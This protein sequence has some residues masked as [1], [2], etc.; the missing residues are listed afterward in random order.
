MTDVTFRSD[1]TVQYIRGIAD[2]QGVIDAAKVSTLGA[3]AQS[4]SDAYADLTPDEF[5]KKLARDTGFINFLTANR[6]GSPFEH[7]CMTFLVSAPIFVFREFMRHRIGISYNE[8]SGRYSILGAEF[9]I[10]G[11]ERAL[12]QI[13]K[14]GAYHYVA[15][16]ESQYE[17]TREVHENTA[18]VAYAGYERL[19]DEGVAKEVARM[20]LPLN[21]FSTMYVTLNARSMMSFL[22]LRTKREDSTFPSYPQREIE[23]VAEQMEAVF[24]ELMP[25]TH[26]TFDKNG[27]VSP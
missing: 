26:A 21:I 8:E 14:P 19:I 20:S 22:S 15:G 2:D 6:H 4:A 23:M 11:P 1:M 5:E 17:S 12:Q 24:A 13:G 3:L 25:I 16:T 10:P 18:R 27:R 9:F 7:N